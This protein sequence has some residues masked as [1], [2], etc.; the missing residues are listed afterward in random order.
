M[1]KRHVFL[2]G[3]FIL[4]LLYSA[5]IIDH[6]GLGGGEVV[7]GYGVPV[8]ML[9]MLA[10]Y[11]ALPILTE[12]SRSSRTQERV[13]EA[14]Q[15]LQIGLIG[16]TLGS[17]AQHLVWRGVYDQKEF[18]TSSGWPLLFLLLLIATF[19]V[20]TLAG[21]LRG[22]DLGLVVGALSFFVASSVFT[23]FSAIYVI[24]SLS[25]TT[26]DCLNHVGDIASRDACILEHGTGAD[27]DLIESGP[28]RAECYAKHGRTED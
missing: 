2:A 12:G 18:F 10:L 22:R 26:E 4:L 1:T 21:R 19:A 24:I 25:D 20:V 17:L 14:K 11:A 16:G 3:T 8:L 15:L 13:G 7:T 5:I 23:V 9:L 28:I 27:C 6:V